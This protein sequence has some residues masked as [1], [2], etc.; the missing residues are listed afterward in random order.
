MDRPLSERCRRVQA[1]RTG[2]V[3]RICNRFTKK[4]QGGGTPCRSGNNDDAQ[5]QQYTE[6]R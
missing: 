3:Q 2:V 5:H 4:R 6:R 1:E